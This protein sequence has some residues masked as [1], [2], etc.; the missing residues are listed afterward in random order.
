MRAISGSTK[1]KLR[2]GS[3]PPSRNPYP[4]VTRTVAIIEKPSACI[5]VR[6]ATSSSR[7]SARTV[8]QTTSPA[9]SSGRKA[10]SYL[11]GASGF[12]RT[13]VTEPTSTIR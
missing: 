5:C 9:G 7:A 11:H 1:V 2:C 8:S 4:N 10:T 13:A 12:A 6:F 3:P